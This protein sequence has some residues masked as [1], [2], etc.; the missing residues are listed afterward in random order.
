MKERGNQRGGFF[1]A[2]FQLIKNNSKDCKSSKLPNLQS[3][4]FGFLLSNYFLFSVKKRLYANKRNQDKPLSRKR[5]YSKHKSIQ[6]LR[7]PKFLVLRI[8]NADVRFE[9]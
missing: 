6:S 4:V 8:K 9:N 3:K 1:K 2:K 7:M 5:V